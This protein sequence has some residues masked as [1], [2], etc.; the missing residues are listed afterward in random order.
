V[1]DDDYNDDYVVMMLSDS[2]YV[3]SI[4]VIDGIG[5]VPVIALEWRI[6]E[7]IPYNLKGE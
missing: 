1:L 3:F 2:L 5:P 7:D 6:R 4:P